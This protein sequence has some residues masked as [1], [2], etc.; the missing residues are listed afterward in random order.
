MGIAFGTDSAESSHAALTG[1]GFHP[2]PVKQLTR[3]F[4]LPESIAEP[5]FALCFLEEEETPALG[6]VVFCQ[7]RTPHI[8]RRPEWLRHANTAQGIR[9]LII[10]SEQ[11][12]AFARTADRLFGHSEA[13]EGGVAVRLPRGCTLGV[14]EPAAF[15]ARFPGATADTPLR[16]AITLNV[17]SLEAA[18]QALESGGVRFHRQDERL[19]VPADQACGVVLEFSA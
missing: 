7:H 1:S 15:D 6:S 13:A 17:T 3:L 16:A 19:R 18:R 4:E 2:R 5:S 12:E 9:A 8:I 14:I 10:G 11:V